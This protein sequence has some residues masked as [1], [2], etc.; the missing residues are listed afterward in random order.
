M[1]DVAQWPAVGHD[2]LDALGDELVVTE[3]IVLEV[4]ILA[5]RAGLSTG[6]HCTERAHPAVGLE[7]LAADDI[8]R[9]LELEQPHHVD[10]R[11]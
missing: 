6:L 9:G 7:L 10:D 8:D 1:G 2:P 4:A 3:D 5:V 11:P